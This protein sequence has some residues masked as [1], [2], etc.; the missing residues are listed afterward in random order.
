MEIVFIAQIAILIFSVILHELGHGYAALALGDHTAKQ[1]NRLSLNPIHHIDPFLTIIMPCLFVFLGLPP[2]GGAKPVP[3]N[4]NYFRFT[5]ARRGMMLVAFA[6]PL[7]NFTLCLVSL[8]LIYV[9][10]SFQSDFV[11]IILFYTLLINA[12]LGAFN[13]FPIPPLDGSKILI[14]IL[15]RA[16]ALKFAII[17]RY[18]FFILIFLVITN[19]LTPIL[20]IVFKFSIGLLPDHY[21][22]QVNS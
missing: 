13:L 9:G 16:Q 12:I 14:G 20:N 7:V 2:L 4:P 1:Q 21:L 11:K 22:P 5:S 6:G 19:A 10:Q 3:V 18:G 8:I 17:E 15:P